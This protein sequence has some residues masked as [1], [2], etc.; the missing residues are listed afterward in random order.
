M[1]IQSKFTDINWYKHTYIWGVTP[2]F[3]FLKF[4]GIL[5]KYVGKVLPTM[6]AFKEVI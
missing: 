2:H 4:V 5:T 3:S 6:T 1:N